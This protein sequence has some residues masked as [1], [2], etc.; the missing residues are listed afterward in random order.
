MYGALRGEYFPFYKNM[1]EVF[2]RL[3]ICEKKYNFVL[4]S[5]IKPI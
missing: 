5:K 4:C 1:S 2:M 3:D